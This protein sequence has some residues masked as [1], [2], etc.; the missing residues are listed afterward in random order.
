MSSKREKL[1]ILKPDNHSK[2]GLPSDPP[3]KL[4][5]IPSIRV[6]SVTQGGSSDTLA[7]SKHGMK[8]ATS[9]LYRVL[10]EI[11][12][13]T[14]S[15]VI[16]Y[17]KNAHDYEGI[18]ASTNFED[19]VFGVTLKYVKEDLY[20][21]PKTLL[22]DQFF[23]ASID[24]DRFTLTFPKP[25]LGTTQGFDNFF[26]HTPH[27]AQSLLAL[28]NSYDTLLAV[29]KFT[30]SMI[31]IS[32]KDG[33]HY[34]GIV[35]ST[36]Y[37]SQEASHI[38]LQANNISKPGAPRI[39]YPLKII[40]I[41]ILEWSSDNLLLEDFF[42]RV[43]IS[44]DRHITPAHAQLHL[45]KHKNVFYQTLVDYGYTGS[46]SLHSGFDEATIH[47][48]KPEQEIYIVLDSD[49]PDGMCTELEEVEWETG[50]YSTGPF[51]LGSA[52]T[53]S[54]QGDDGTG[55]DDQGK[56]SYWKGKGKDNDQG[57][58]DSGEGGALGGGGSAGDA[59]GNSGGG[60]GGG[61]GRGSSGGGGGKGSSGG[62][63][64]G[65]GG[66]AD[67]EE[68]RGGG[69]EDVNMNDGTSVMPNGGADHG[70]IK[71]PFFSTLISKDRKENFQIVAHIKATVNKNASSGLCG[72]SVGVDIEMLHVASQS[73]A[74]RFTL[75]QCQTHIVASSCRTNVIHWSPRVV[76]AEDSSKLQEDQS[77]TGAGSLNI[78]MNPSLCLDGKYGSTKG[79]ERT[80]QPWVIGSNRLEQDNGL[81]AGHK[82]VFWNYI[83]NIE[84]GFQSTVNEDFNPKPSL[85]FV[86]GLERGRCPLVLPKLEVQVA[87]FWSFASG[88]RLLSW[89]F[90]SKIKGGSE[91]LPANLNFMH[92]VS[93]V[94]DLQGFGGDD[95][96][97]DGDVTDEIPVLLV[98]GDRTLFGVR[99]LIPEQWLT[100]EV[101]IQQAVEGRIGGLA[102][103]QQSSS[104]LLSPVWST[105]S[106]S[107][108][109][110]PTPT[111]S[112][113]HTPP[114]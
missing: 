28:E 49:V 50:D 108:A 33:N 55:D 78:S 40:S 71:V 110:Y 26:S 24:I 51:G 114:A 9:D 102:R 68:R 80:Q 43:Y 57:G 52:L 74:D 104:H 25:S 59:G 64:K 12:D 44:T 96:V 32:T 17:T 54:S 69:D 99:Q 103:E 92:Q 112:P 34:Q 109:P 83:R 89:A 90:Y 18:V 85:E 62:G 10:Q 97:I 58:L 70:F 101:T 11:S 8:Q 113:S 38:F 53:E 4:S 65:E 22:K 5:S 41:D 14:G 94:V 75:S 66:D 37:N 67:G 7:E 46:Y 72:P 35:K 19:N 61:G 77:L 60:G 29:S 48:Q 3:L 100:L 47:L 30:D 1:S 88:K 82:G 81:A 13:H 27:T 84:G 87:S 106:T 31:A 63:G 2:T 91:G 107:T 21:N 45:I 15:R 36:G 73:H 56:G 20:S 93:M 98:E 23:I 42:H 95:I 79:T 105:A 6:E 39:N 16:I 76:H 111:A 86:L